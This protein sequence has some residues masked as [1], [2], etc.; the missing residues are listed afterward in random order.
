MKLVYFSPDQV[1]AIVQALPSCANARLE[2]FLSAMQPKDAGLFEWTDTPGTDDGINFIVPGGAGV[3]A[4]GPGYIRTS[5]AAAAISGIVSNPSVSGAV[6]DALKVGAQ[7]GIVYVSPAGGTTDDDPRMIA[8][9]TACSGKYPVVQA[10]G[11]WRSGSTTYTVVQA[12]DGVVQAY[13]AAV[14]SA[15]A[16]NVGSRFARVVLAPL[17]SALDDDARL[18]AVAAACK[19]AGYPLEQI[20]GTWYSGATPYVVGPTPTTVTIDPADMWNSDTTR[21]AFAEAHLTV[22][23]RVATRMT[24][25][26]DADLASF[27]TQ[28]EIAIGINGTYAASS[29]G[30][31]GESVVSAII[32]AGTVSVIVRDGTKNYAALG[33]RGLSVSISGPASIGVVA[34]TAPAHRL[35]VLA[36]SIGCGFLCT[37]PTKE[38]WPMLIRDAGTYAVTC[39]AG[40]G[41]SMGQFGVAPATIVAALAGAVDGTSDTTIWIALG[42]ND[43]AAQVTAA[44]YQAYAAALVDALHAAYATARIVLQSP[45]SATVETFGAVTLT[46]Y[47]EAILAVCA[48]RSWCTQVNGATQITAALSGDG[49]HPATAGNVTYAASVTTLLATINTWQPTS[50]ATLARWIDGA[51]FAPGGNVANWAD[52]KDAHDSTQATGNL[53]GAL[54]KSDANYGG[55]PVVDLAGGKCYQSDAFNVTQPCTW[56][57][58]GNTDGGANGTLADGVTTHCVV[59]TNGSVGRPAVYAGTGW[60]ADVGVDMTQPHCYVVV[61]NGVSSKLYRD[62][63][64]APVASG[65]A[66]ANGVVGGVLTGKRHDTSDKC[67]GKIACEV[68]IG[69]ALDASGVANAM[70]WAGKKYG[71]A[72]T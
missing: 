48:T 23:S 54:V 64:A 12:S 5:S 67:N 31:V 44:T 57:I 10:A 20:P 56:I 72:W 46:Q 18:A 24:V 58:V 65:N 29:V 52:N 42:Y 34:K 63:S 28:A 66:G 68:L 61:C 45:I 30:P 27:A 22:T 36:D 55:Q 11:T 40:G 70:A 59:G 13:S 71:H 60:V 3:G 62:A 25:H 9:L 2:N 43:A 53:Q 26:A 69:E 49:V 7:F 21:P 33:C 19:T 38:A 17:G 8:I 37:H 47:R 14:A 4:V 32:P 1:I 16:L 35:I 51:S 39:H 15:L 6:A 50:V 41:W